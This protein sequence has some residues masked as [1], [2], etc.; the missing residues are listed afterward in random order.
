[1]SI[2]FPSLSILPLD[3]NQFCNLINSNEQIGADGGHWKKLII[4]QG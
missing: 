1:M 4:A 3:S 2:K